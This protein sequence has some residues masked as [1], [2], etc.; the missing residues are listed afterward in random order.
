MCKAII[1]SAKNGLKSLGYVSNLSTCVK[2]LNELLPADTQMSFADISSI[3][4]S[5]KHVY[6]NSFGYPADKNGLPV[7]KD[8]ATYLFFETGKK[9]T[10]G[11]DII[12]W[13]ART[14][15]KGI[16]QGVIWGT[17][18]KLESQIRQSRLF[19]IDDIC[20]KSKMDGEAFL[21]EIAASTIPETWTFK[22]KPSSIN[23][24]ILKSYLENIFKRLKYEYQDG[25]P[26]KLVY[27]NNG[28]YLLFNSNLLDK[29][30]HEVLIVVEVHKI[31]DGESILMNPR[32]VRNR[33]QLMKMDFDRDVHVEQ[34]SFFEKVEE[35]VFQDSW[36]ID[37]DYD[38]F[39]HIIEDRLARFPLDMQKEPTEQLSRKLDDAISF[40]VAIAKRNYKFVVP[41]Y[42][43][44]DNKIQLLMPIYLKGS[45]SSMPD[46]ALILTPDKEHQLYSP[47]TILPLDAVYQDARLIA[48]PDDTWL[49][50]DTIL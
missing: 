4:D 40:A 29:F 10:E 11:K 32:R 47:E 27:S 14:N 38:T 7:T 31:G 28:K 2:E 44:Q 35:V 46:F 5:G 42:R 33:S 8:N 19:H 3:A 12:G 41:M 37:R 43:P 15:R 26:N 16:F 17:K 36:L 50:P 18:T 9:N 6:L 34:P 30:F 21:E 48:K 45:Y 13:F 20:F 22:N 23:H 24:P 25:K 39:S 49:N 1:N